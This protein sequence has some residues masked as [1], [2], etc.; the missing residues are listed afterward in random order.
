MPRVDVA[1]HMQKTRPPARTISGD[2]FESTQDGVTYY[3]HV[4]EEIKVIGNASSKYLGNLV[5]LR[6]LLTLALK[7][8]GAMLHLEEGDE[9]S[10]LLRSLVEEIQGHIVSWTWTDSKGK[11]YPKEPSVADVD[12]LPFDEFMV[13]LLTFSPTMPDVPLETP[14]E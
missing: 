11:P 10:T 14:A 3:P 9:I 13:L 12:S 7:E 1:Q 4:G 8:N 5:K 6:S 2:L